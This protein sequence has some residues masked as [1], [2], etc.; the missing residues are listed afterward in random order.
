M[1]LRR[2]TTQTK[3]VD[4]IACVKHTARMIRWPRRGWQAAIS[5]IREGE[6]F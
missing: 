5:T 3:R 4:C 6:T 1:R 2:Y